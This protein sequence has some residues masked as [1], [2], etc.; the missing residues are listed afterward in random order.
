[1]WVVCLWQS[2]FALIGLATLSGQWPL[3]IRQCLLASPKLY[4]NLHG[5]KFEPT[6][7]NVTQ[8]S[9]EIHP[10]SVSQGNDPPP[11]L[12]SSMLE[13]ASVCYECWGVPFLGILSKRWSPKW[14]FKTGSMRFGR[15]MIDTT[16]MCMLTKGFFPFQFNNPSQGKE[17]LNCGPW[18]CRN[19]L[20]V[21]N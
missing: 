8:G 19:T 4:M 3:L 10:Q 6:F 20:I 5:D 9:K 16:H 2:Y 21:L 14:F 11:N 1:M 15:F 12:E 13:Y 7:H 17:I 18:I